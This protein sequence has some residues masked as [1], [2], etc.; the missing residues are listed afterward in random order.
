MAE[1]IKWKSKIILAKAEAVYGT[2]PGLTAAA[3]AMLLTNVTLTPMDGEDVS[4]DLELP[5]L[6]AQ[7]SLPA[8]L[9]VRLTARVELAP[10]GTPGTPPP[11]GVLM[12]GLGCAET[13][14]AGTSVTYNPVSAGHESLY[15]KF[16]IGP[17]LHAFC[18]A[19]GTAKIRCTAQG[20]PVIE[21]DYTGLFLPPSEVARPNPVLTAF[22]APQ[23]VSSTNTPLF[24]VAGVP[25]VMREYVLDLGNQ[26]EG[27]FLVGRN[28][29]L[30]NDRAETVTARVEAVPLAQYDPYAAALDGD[31]RVAVVLTHG[32][33]AGKI[34][35]LA[36]PAA[37]QK[38]LTGLENSQNILEWPLTL[39]PLPVNGNDQWTLTLT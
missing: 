26:V 7:A 13:I 24:T 8:S 21:L 38:R 5:Y 22:K 3:N 15:V 23:I 33:G 9:K 11:W 19:R 27:R 6:G 36:I 34:A 17:T 10:S 37:Q 2:D 31:R 28:S 39:S 25:L 4:R 29:V 32:I 1:P 35:T 14:A 30:I 12:R 16:W 18:G 20:L